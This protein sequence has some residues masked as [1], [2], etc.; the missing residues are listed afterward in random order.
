MKQF[1]AP[2]P[3]AKNSGAASLLSP[4]ASKPPYSASNQSSS[5]AS[6]S[7]LQI[8][9]KSPDQAHY[10]SL[11]KPFTLLTSQIPQLFESDLKPLADEM[12]SL[13]MFVTRFKLRHRTENWLHTCEKILHLFSKKQY[14][15]LAEPIQALEKMIKFV[16]VFMC[17]FSFKLTNFFSTT[18][19]FAKFPLLQHL[20][21][22]NL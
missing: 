16:Y 20:N 2:K 1:A 5:S 7:S 6:A 14:F 9:L 4:H 15:T 8:E 19:L 17:Y 3:N 10:E 13:E 18:V 12:Y 22:L 11:Q 21:F